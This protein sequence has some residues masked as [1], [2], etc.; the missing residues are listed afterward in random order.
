MHSVRIE[1][2]K[3]ILAD[4]R[5]TYQAAGDAGY[6]LASCNCLERMRVVR[7]KRMPTTRCYDN[8]TENSAPA[9]RASV[10]F[11]ANRLGF[12]WAPT[13]LWNSYFFNQ[14]Q[15]TVFIGMY[16]VESMVF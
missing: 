12:G 1:L 6:S 14:I 4:T 9:R 2:A 11:V 5:I 13:Y 7:Y 8:A 10:C 15:T 16:Q 3:L